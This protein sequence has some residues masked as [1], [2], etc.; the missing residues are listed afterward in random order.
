MHALARFLTDQQLWIV[1]LS[2]FLLMVIVR[3]LAES[4][5]RR[6]SNAVG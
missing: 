4:I 2:L 3:S 5:R 6:R 1:G